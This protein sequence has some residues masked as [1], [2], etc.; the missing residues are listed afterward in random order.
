[1]ASHSFS[2]QS[3]N[4]WESA[5][6]PKFRGGWL[7]LKNILKAHSSLT[8]DHC[9]AVDIYTQTSNL[10]LDFGRQQSELKITDTVCPLFLRYSSCFLQTASGQN[11]LS[12]TL[13]LIVLG[14]DLMKYLLLYY[15]CESSIS[16]LNWSLLFPPIIFEMFV[17]HRDCKY[18][19]LKYVE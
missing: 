16:T 4:V 2:C 14:L 9:P 19:F 15:H 10:V 18:H 7:C 11:N 8:L 6:R 5:L 12:F 13:M 17:I 1:M 3:V